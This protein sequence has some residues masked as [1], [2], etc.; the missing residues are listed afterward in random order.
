MGD[1][2]CFCRF[3]FAFSRIPSFQLRR[4]MGGVCRGEKD[5]VGGECLSAEVVTVVV[6]TTVT[7]S[8]T[9]TTFTTRE[10]S[11][12]A[13]GRSGRPTTSTSS[14]ARRSTSTRSSTSTSGATSTRNAGARCPLAVAACSCSKGRVRAACRGTP[15]GILTM[16]RKDVRAVL[17]LNLRSHLMTATNLSGR[18]PSRLGST[19]S[20]AGCLSRFAPSLRAMAVLRPSVVLS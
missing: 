20:G 15:R 7:I 12:R 1:V 10:T 17:T 4:R 14:S 8:T 5:R 11:S 3:C 2:H 9:P 19:F 16:C 6:T 18:I 13:V